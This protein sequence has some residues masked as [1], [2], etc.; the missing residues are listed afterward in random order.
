MNYPGYNTGSVL[1][2]EGEWFP[3]RVHNHIQLQ[4]GEY[5]FILQ[6][7][8]GLKH[9]LPA[10]FYN[11]YGFNTGDEIICKIDRINCT[12]RILLEPRHPYYEIGEKYYFDVVE[13]LE[14]DRL[15]ILLVKDIFG[16]CIKVPFYENKIDNTYFN[17]QV[18]CVV[19]DISKGEIFL[20]ILPNTN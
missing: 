7:I 8:N 10:A 5:Y 12:G 20:D 14:N 19:R 18:Y 2:S 6:D 9:F 1:L 15:K 17:N 13:Y 11:N 4:D 16:N 3:F